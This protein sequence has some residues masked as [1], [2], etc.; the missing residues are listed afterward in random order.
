L[1]E[2]SDEREETLQVMYKVMLD[3]TVMLAPFIPFT[4][5]KIYQ[6][7][8]RPIEKAESVHLLEWP[9]ANEKLIDTKLELEFAYANDVVSSML[10]LREKI[11]R[12]IKWPVKYATL[13]TEN[14]ELSSA[15]KKYAGLIERLANVLEVRISH[16]LKGITHEIKPDFSKI[17]QKFGRKSAEVAVA[18]SRIS[19]ES[20]LKN[21]HREN[22]FVLEVNGEKVELQHDDFLIEEILPGGLV[23]GMFGSYSLYLDVEETREMLQLGFMRE[24]TR[25]VQAL[26]KKAGL[27]KKDKIALFVSAPAK[28]QATLEAKKKEIAEKVGAKSLDFVAT[29]AV[30]ARKHRDKLSAKEFEVQFGF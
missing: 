22:K 10:A 4:T 25:A 15:V 6:D 2:D 8:F 27:R 29:K 9:A 30:E 24:F 12:G 16:E 28:S 7:V 23:G 17:G 21:L 18:V 14:E 11:P 3:L 13:V 26:R 1:S 19:P 20:I 5:E